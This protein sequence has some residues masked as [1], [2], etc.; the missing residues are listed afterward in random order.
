MAKDSFEYMDILSCAEEFIFKS[1]AAGAYVL[2][3]DCIFWLGLSW[4]I[5]VNPA[6]IATSSGLMYL[7]CPAV[8][9]ENSAICI[10]FLISYGDSVVL[11]TLTAALL[12]IIV[13][14][15]LGISRL[16]VS[17][18]FSNGVTVTV[19]FYAVGYSIKSV[20]V[21][22]VDFDGIIRA[23]PLRTDWSFAGVSLEAVITCVAVC[24]K[25]MR[26][27]L[28]SKTTLLFLTTCNPMV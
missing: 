27:R 12:S 22:V 14:I 1:N 21:V 4:I 18:K 5:G 16:A 9:N 7:D 23:S 8:T 28:L 2:L 19:V 3:F 25:C 24:G 6:R 13:D 26:P 11:V 20:I 17:T 10:L 15:E